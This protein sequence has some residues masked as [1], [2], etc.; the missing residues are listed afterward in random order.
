MDAVEVAAEEEERTDAEEEEGDEDDDEDEEDL[1]RRLVDGPVEKRENRGEGR[2]LGGSE[3]EVDEDVEEDVAEVEEEVGVDKEGKDGALEAVEEPPRTRRR[4]VARPPLLSAGRAR[5][6]LLRLLSGSPEVGPGGEILTGIDLRSK[7]I[8]LTG[9]G[10]L[11]SPALAVEAA[12]AAAAAKEGRPSAWRGI[13]GIAWRVPDWGPSSDPPWLHWSSVSCLGSSKRQVGQV[14]CF[15]SHG[16][17]QSRWKRCLQG[18]QVM[19][20]PGSNFSWQTTQLL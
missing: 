16:T 2:N 8:R 6:R 10:P 18:K 12:E 4:L 13:G 5:T 3:A 19:S 14:L 15:S 9:T 17:T 11:T 1:L 7:F 20:S